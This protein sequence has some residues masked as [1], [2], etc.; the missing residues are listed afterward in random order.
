MVAMSVK[1]QREREM[2]AMSV[3]VQREREM[4]AMS[5]KVSDFTYSI[6]NVHVHGKHWEPGH[7]TLYFR[8]LYN[9]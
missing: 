4:V 9:W 6:L 1:V 8:S 3:K 7:L 5:V 2:V